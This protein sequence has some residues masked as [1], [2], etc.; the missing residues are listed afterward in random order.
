[1]SGNTFAIAL[2]LLAALSVKHFLIDF[3]FQGP[4][5]Y[6]NKGK[7]MHPGGLAHAGLHAWATLAIVAPTHTPM[8]YWIFLG[9][10]V[11]HYLMD[12]TKVNI[13][14]HYGWGANTHSEF[15]ILLGVD[16]LVH[17]MTYVAIFGIVMEQF[18]R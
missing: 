12:Y 10:F 14:K 6:L 5:M 1:M 13:N 16:Q 8:M 15:W 7:W 2:Y 11:I 17:T 3:V 18:V 9:E 4:W